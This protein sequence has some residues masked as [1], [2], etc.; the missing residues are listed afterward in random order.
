[1]GSARDT[2]V[3]VCGDVLVSVPDDLD[4]LA[5]YVLREQ[6]D[7]FEDEIRF[8]RAALAPGELVVDVGANYGVYALAAA[9]VVGAAGR[10]VAFEPGA[11]PARHLGRSVKANRFPWLDVVTAGL[12]DRSGRGWLAGADAALAEVVEDAGGSGGEEISLLT[13]DEADARWG[14]GAASFLKMDAEGHE[15]RILEGGHRYFAGASP[16]V[17]VEV[18]TGERLDL[19]L[20]ER[21]ARWGYQPLGLLPGLGQLAP[22][23]PAQ[24]LDAYQLNLFVARP[25][26]QARLAERG[27]LAGALRPVP[28]PGDAGWEQPLLRY[29]VVREACRRWRGPGEGEH[30]RSLAAWVAAHAPA[31]AAGDRWS[32]LAQARASAEAAFNQDPALGRAAT[33]AR[34]SA[35]LGERA[36]AVKVLQA[37]A[38]GAL[39]GAPFP[40]EPFLP[41][42]PALELVEPAGDPGRLLLAM[43]LERLERLRAHSSLFVAADDGLLE[44]LARLGFGPPEM[45]RR[46][47]L[48]RLRAGI[49][50]APQPSPLLAAPG[51]DN[52][53]PTY[54]SGAR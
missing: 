25:D 23:S 50:G 26:R 41:P 53:N 43:V 38:Q 24:T 20:P 10:V 34:V 40:A 36:T 51:P 8:V 32:L 48:V 37:A 15:P 5:T 19:S 17:M 30:A 27:R 13:L 47:Q 46:R 12:S 33:L 52:L 31:T 3:R 9:Q 18:R 45:E 6:E 42:S 16:L 29:P 35:E 28:V 22:L 7:W 2:Y 21:L 11:A 14:L 1:M 4:E 54:W 39:A 44:R 49:Q